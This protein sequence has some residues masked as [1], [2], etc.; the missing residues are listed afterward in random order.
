MVRLALILAVAILEYVNGKIPRLP[1]LPFVDGCFY[2]SE[3]VGTYRVE[4]EPTILSFPMFMRVL[5][6]RKIAPTMAKYLITKKNVTEGAPHDGEG[7]VQQHDKQLWFLPAQASDSGEYTCTYRNETYCVQ[8]NITLQVYKSSSVDAKN[9]SHRVSVQVGESLTF[10]CPN[11]PDFNRTGGLIEWYK[12]SSS[13]SVQADRA[14]SSPWDTGNLMIPA[15]KR[16]HEGLYTCQLRVLVNNQQYKVSRVVLLCLQG[17]TTLP[18]CMTSD[19]ES[20]IISSST[21]PQPH[22]IRPPVIVSPLNGTVFGSLHGAGL[23]LS[24]KVLTD[25]DMSEST[26][27]TWRVNGQSVESSYL[28]GRALQGWK[29]VTRV[30]EGCQTEMR[31]A[32][33]AV[34]EEDVKTE[35]KCITENPGGKQEVFVQLQLE[36]STLTWLVFGVVAA[37]CFLTVVLIFLYVLFKPKRKN[38]MDYFLARQNSTF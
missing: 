27:V 33:V 23:E 3:E 31:L 29:R 16:H 15:V 11:L 21:T 2:T 32:V 38:K 1:P 35:L 20:T 26:L 18:I 37:F 28:D 34:T 22:V 30:S 6:V 9:L 5:K 14:S 7:R 19:P 24:C 25:C 17:T 8:G 10:S 36:D 4:G 13:T 12:N